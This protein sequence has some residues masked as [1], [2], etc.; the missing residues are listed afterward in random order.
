MENVKIVR[1]SFI[2]IRQ[3]RLL[4][5]KNWEIRQ[6]WENIYSYM[7][8]AG[9][10]GRGRTLARKNYGKRKLRKKREGMEGKVKLEGKKKGKEGI[11]E[12]FRNLGVR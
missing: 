9:K 4:F 12:L 3:S 8:Y 7:H 1:S 5:T 11:G 6:N 2:K 10:K